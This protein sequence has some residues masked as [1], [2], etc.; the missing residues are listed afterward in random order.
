MPSEETTSTVAIVQTRCNVTPSLF[1]QYI[2]TETVISRKYKDGWLYVLKH[3]TPKTFNYFDEAIAKLDQHLKTEHKAKESFFIADS[4]TTDKVLIGVSGSVY[5][6]K[7]FDKKTQ[8]L[9]RSVDVWRMQSTVPPRKRSAKAD[10][11]LIPGLK[12]LSKQLHVDFAINVHGGEGKRKRE[13][14][15]SIYEEMDKREKKPKRAYVKKEKPSLPPAPIMSEEL[16]K[17]MHTTMAMKD[18]LIETQATII[19]TLQVH[20]QM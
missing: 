16:I 10:P 1:G 14:T 5:M 18:K 17:L 6:S 4:E 2:G 12:R 3:E 13:P 11:L 19:A 9:R 7:I 8:Q 20:K 15:R